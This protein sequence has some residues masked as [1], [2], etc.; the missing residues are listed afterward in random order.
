MERGFSLR[1]YLWLAG[2]LF[3]LAA[4]LSFLA[5][6]LFALPWWAMVLM[7]GSLIALVVEG[8]EHTLA[9]PL[10]RLTKAAG[11]TRDGVPVLPPPP[12]GPVKA[13]EISRLWR[14]M[15]QYQDHLTQ[16]R[17]AKQALE[18]R[19]S[20]LKAQVRMLETAGQ[21][22]EPAVAVDEVAPALLKDLA[23]TLGVPD[24]YLV[25]LRRHCPVPVIGATGTPAW[26]DALRASGLTPWEDVLAEGRP[27]SL[28][29]TGLAPAWREHWGHG[30]LWVVPLS[31]HGKAQGLLLSAPGVERTPTPDELTLVSA[32]A[33][34]LACALHPPRWSDERKLG[35][36]SRP[37]TASEVSPAPEA[38]APE[39]PPEPMEAAAA[40]DT[41][42]EMP[43]QGRKSRRRRQKRGA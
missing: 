29:L 28:C 22:L 39:A 4:C 31:Y 12:S 2:S 16:S 42:I 18:S 36:P 20:G 6:L 13:H 3:I 9:R 1:T 24:L 32:L 37:A 33:Q 5:Y 19:V 10:E 7:L 25:P 17:H 26:A 11:R 41:P 14:G 30:A 38:P 8:L 15:R 43:A 34:I 27:V 40:D 21:M 23:A 35:A